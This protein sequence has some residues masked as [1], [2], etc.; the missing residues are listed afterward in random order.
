MRTKNNENMIKECLIVQ[1]QAL[2]KPDC[3][4]TD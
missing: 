4:E 1:M 3:S 2:F